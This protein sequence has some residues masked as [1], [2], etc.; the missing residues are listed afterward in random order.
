VLCGE[1]LSGDEPGAGDLPERDVYRLRAGGA[2][3]LC[4]QELSVE[5]GLRPHGHARD[6]HSVRAGGAAMLCG[7]QLP[8]GDELPAGHLSGQP[9]GAALR[10]RR[11]ERW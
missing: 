2:A 1:Q 3:V 9:G 4:G 7:R 11:C 5:R 8:G 10:S 6:L